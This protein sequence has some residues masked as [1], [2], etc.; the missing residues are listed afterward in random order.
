M[1]TKKIF[2]LCL[3]ISMGII[4]GV[5]NQPDNFV[6][7]YENISEVPLAET[8]I[9]INMNNGSRLNQVMK[10]MLDISRD[11]D[12]KYV[13]GRW[14]LGKIGGKNFSGGQLPEDIFRLKGEIVYNDKVAYKD[15]KMTGAWWSND[16][17]GYLILF[18]AKDIYW[19][20]SQ[21][22]FESPLD[23]AQEII[24][25]PY[26]GT[27]LPQWNSIAEVFHPISQ[28]ILGDE[29]ISFCMVDATGEDEMLNIPKRLAMIVKVGSTGMTLKIL[30][31]GF[32]AGLK[33][34]KA[35]SSDN[36]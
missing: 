6:P 8:A 29:K 4:L 17:D 14:E 13:E 1:T 18:Q 33:V 16:I 32:T 35:S 24:S 20:V 12:Y 5:S 30:P 19:P 15:P 21:V 25:K 26:N 9:T 27:D 36:N 7:K 31:I 2:L 11:L 3:G 10:L 28:D 22:I 34:T 23:E